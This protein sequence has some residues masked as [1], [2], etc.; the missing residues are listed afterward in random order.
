[1]TGNAVLLAEVRRLLRA[2]FITRTVGCEC[3]TKV[4][5]VND[6]PDDGE[7][8]SFY[9]LVSPSYLFKTH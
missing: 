3:W 9:R 1:M 2:T 5:S 7:D 6:L 8:T 4:G